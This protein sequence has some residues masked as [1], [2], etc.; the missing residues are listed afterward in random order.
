MLRQAPATATPKTA[1]AASG[2]LTS[3]ERLA[4]QKEMLRKRLEERATAEQKAAPEGAGEAGAGASFPTR[5]GAG[6]KPMPSAARK[7]S[8]AYLSAI[9]RMIPSEPTVIECQPEKRPAPGRNGPLS[10]PYAP[11]PLLDGVGRGTF[12]V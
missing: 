2:K 11:M 12:P 10:I 9:L 6:I 5:A 3:E 7:T 4:E 8:G 1:T